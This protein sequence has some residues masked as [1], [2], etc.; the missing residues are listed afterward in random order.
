[1]FLQ[2][3]SVSLLLSARQRERE[4]ERAR[5]RERERE[6]DSSAGIRRRIPLQEESRST[7]RTG[8]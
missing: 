4:R 7:L 1:M 2:R 5:E 6:D 8:F 3:R